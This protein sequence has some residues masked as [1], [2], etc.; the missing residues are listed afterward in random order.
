M[1]MK[2]FVGELI[3]KKSAQMDVHLNVDIQRIDDGTEEIE[4]P[5]PVKVDGMIYVAE[6]III[7]EAHIETELKL[8]CSRCLQPFITKFE[9]VVNEKFTLN[10]G[11]KDDDV[12]FMSSDSIDIT[13]IIANDIILSLP[14]KR[15][16]KDDCKGLCQVCGANL[17]TTTCS[18]NEN[19]IDPRLAKLKDIFF[20][21]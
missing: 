21:N 16:C 17:N 15:L 13:K 9:N 6:E 8:T 12:T 19:E 2:I 4:V 11:N 5:T 3:K 10:E 7:F 18:C 1:D 14:I 20:T